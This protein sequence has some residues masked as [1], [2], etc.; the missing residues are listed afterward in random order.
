MLIFSIIIPNYNHA[1]FL[2][3]RIKSILQQSMQDFE[4]IILDDASTDNSREIIEGYRSNNKITHIV[5][6]EKN[7]NSLLAQ[8][9][10]GIE[11]AK[12]DWIWIAESDDIANRGFLEQ[13]VN[14]IQKHQTAGL[15]YSDSNVLDETTQKITSRFSE[16]RNSIFKTQKWNNAYFQNGITEI[17]EYLKYDCT[18]NNVSAAVFKRDLALPI[19]QATQFRYYADWYLFLQLC[20][21]TD[22][23]YSPKSLNTYRRH[24]NSLLNAETSLVNSKKEYF[25]I[26]KLLYNSNEVTA[27][28][29]LLSHFAFNYLSFGV[30]KDGRGK[31]FSIIKSYFASDQRLAGK[32]LS[33]IFLIKLFYQRYKAKFELTD[34]PTPGSKLF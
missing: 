30:F 29:K 26:L 24:P 31:I 3:Q 1:N 16:R 28:K 10:K 13:C 15:W 7:S 8:W 21:V 27:K 25:E 22:I 20:L 6:N 34:K 23:C 19:V 17:N 2:Q 9:K 14:D 4:I 32:V 33:K 11:L 12:G 18:V 5:L